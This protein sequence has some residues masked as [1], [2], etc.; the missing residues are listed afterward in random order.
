MSQKGKSKDH[1]FKIIPLQENAE[2]KHIVEEG[3]AAW[4]SCYM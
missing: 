1:L 3:V 2:K 4:S